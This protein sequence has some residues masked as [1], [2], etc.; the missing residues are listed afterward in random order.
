[1]CHIKTTFGWLFLRYVYVPAY[2]AGSTLKPVS[3]IA[4]RVA[5]SRK[6]SSGSGR[7]FGNVQSLCLLR[8][9]MATVSSAVP[10]RQTIPPAANSTRSFAVSADCFSHFVQR[11]VN[12]GKNEDSRFHIG[13]K[14]LFVGSG[15]PRSVAR[16]P[17]SASVAAEET[18]IS[19]ASP[20]L[21]PPGTRDGNQDES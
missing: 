3:S 19:F 18:R 12:I 6:L 15:F 2:D 5:V 9:M 8:W 7:P 13:L 1:M 20:F 10:R 17:G 4:S 16:W 11:L 14:S 21:L